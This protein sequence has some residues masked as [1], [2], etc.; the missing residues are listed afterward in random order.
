VIK[1]VVFARLPRAGLCNKLLVWARA[2]VFAH[3]YGLPLYVFG[4]SEFKIGPYLRF[5]RSKRRYWGYFK[6]HSKPGMI[7]S[8]IF[9]FCY[10]IKN[11]PNLD[12]SMSHSVLNT[13][14][15]YLF[16][17]VPP[18]PDYFNGLRGQ[19][20]LVRS[21]FMSILHPRCIKEMNKQNAPVIGV[22]I[23]RSDFRDLSQ[24]ELL[25]ESGNVRTPLL[26]YIEV[27]LALRE[28]TGRTLPVTVFTDGYED[29]VAEVLALPR[30]SM[31]ATNSDILDLINLSQSTCLV[32]SIGSTFSYWA[33]YISTG[34]IITHS[35]DSTHF[36]SIDSNASQREFKFKSNEPW[37]P[38]LVNRITDITKKMSLG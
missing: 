10:K 32:T 14:E 9:P 20:E 29:D 26:Y 12:D 35:A 33:A 24:D 37:D 17:T 5:E 11:E 38:L 3:K 31:S 34:L 6:S 8:L 19:E 23:R 28:M 1:S 4:W 2:F 18:W 7:L 13:K 36:A 16:D 27:I 15:L 30:V 21:A 22:H 25:G